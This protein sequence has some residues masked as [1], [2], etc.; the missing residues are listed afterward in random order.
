MT[1]RNSVAVLAAGERD[2]TSHNDKKCVLRASVVPKTRRGRK[3]DRPNAAASAGAHGIPY[4]VVVYTRRAR[5]VEF[6]AS[7][8]ASVSA[9]SA[10][11]R[12][13]DYN[14]ISGAHRLASEDKVPPLLVG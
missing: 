5:I 4:S 7:R 6:T 3:M 1:S 10:A 8:A 11:R 14:E 13:S 2:K 12:R 9:R